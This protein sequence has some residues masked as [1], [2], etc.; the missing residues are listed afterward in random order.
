MRSSRIARP[1][2]HLERTEITTHGIESDRE[3]R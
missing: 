2:D 1:S 3:I